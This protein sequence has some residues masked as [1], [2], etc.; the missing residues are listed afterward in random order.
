[1]GRQGQLLSED[2]H[3]HVFESMSESTALLRPCKIDVTHAFLLTSW[4]A[5]W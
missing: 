1:M 2:T 3:P 4:S 5:A